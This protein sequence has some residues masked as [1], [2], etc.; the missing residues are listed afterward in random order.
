MHITIAV[1]IEKLLQKENEDYLIVLFVVLSWLDKRS[2]INTNLSAAQ[3]S[4]SQA[5]HI[6][7]LYK[8]WRSYN[9]QY[10]LSIC[11]WYTVLINGSKKIQFL[12]IQLKIRYVLLILLQIN[13]LGGKNIP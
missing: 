10:Q 4:F 1:G 8:L 12:Q 7:W 5:W 13:S 9:K 6:A 3:T 11:K 2:T